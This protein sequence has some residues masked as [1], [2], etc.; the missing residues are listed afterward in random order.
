[1]NGYSKMLKSQEI[2]TV[3]N[4]QKQFF[5]TKT[6]L[7]YEYRYEQLTKLKNAVLKY[8]TAL[9]LALQKD[10]GKSKLE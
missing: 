7:S 8:E 6:T 9:T 3:F 5:N 1:M 2:S 10:L 4:E